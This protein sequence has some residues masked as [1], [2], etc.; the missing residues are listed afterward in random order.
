[1][2]YFVLGLALIGITIVMVLVGRPRNGESALFLK[3]WV[4]GQAYALVAMASS[5]AGV[6]MAITNWPF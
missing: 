4:A 6:T 5:V 2:T 3:S 1:M